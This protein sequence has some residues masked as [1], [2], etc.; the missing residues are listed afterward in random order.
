MSAG[1]GREGRIGHSLIVLGG[2]GAGESVPGNQPNPGQ[3]SAHFVPWL[4]TAGGTISQVLRDILDRGASAENIRLVSA[5]C[6]SPALKLLSEQFPGLKI[7]TGVCGCF[8][9]VC[10]RVCDCVVCMGL[11][12]V[13]VLGEYLVLCMYT[14]NQPIPPAAARHDRCGAE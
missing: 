11:R 3:P 1:R 4:R 8:C 2:A 7:Y 5:V 12:G 10:A 13:W 9:C 6:A 14:H